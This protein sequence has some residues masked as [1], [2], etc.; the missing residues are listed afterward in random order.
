MY[1]FLKVSSFLDV[2]VGIVTDDVP[3]VVYSHH[4]MRSFVLLVEPNAPLGLT[5]R[6]LVFAAQTAA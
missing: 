3:H 2:S 5:D 4:V 6:C 1:H